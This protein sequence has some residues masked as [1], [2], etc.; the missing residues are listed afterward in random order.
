M[1]TDAVGRLGKTESPLGPKF[2]HNGHSDVS[3]SG[4]DGIM[5][6]VTVFRRIWGF[7]IAWVILHTAF[8]MYGITLRFAEFE[9]SGD[10][11]LDYYLLLLFYAGVR[12][13]ESLQYYSIRALESISASCL[14]WFIFRHHLS[15]V[16]CI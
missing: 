11:T 9:I 10:V 2:W 6:H 8:N 1:N 4:D 5:V 16:S 13:L 3:M 14:D 12:N 15:I 7:G